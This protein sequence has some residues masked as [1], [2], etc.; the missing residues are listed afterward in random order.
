MALLSAL[1]LV[2]RLTSVAFLYLP[3]R[4]AIQGQVVC[5]HPEPFHYCALQRDGLF[6]LTISADNFGTLC[7]VAPRLQTLQH[8]YTLQPTIQWIPFKV[9]REACWVVGVFRNAGPAAPPS[10]EY[11]LQPASPLVHTCDRSTNDHVMVTRVDELPIEGDGT[12]YL[13]LRQESSR[14][15]V[16][17]IGV[18]VDVRAVD[19]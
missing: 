18:Y 15:P 11:A 4:T 17:V 13:S 10:A 3:A 14:Q 7:P 16:E 2:T 5:E 6:A 19:Q 1:L 12:C 8:P 9:G